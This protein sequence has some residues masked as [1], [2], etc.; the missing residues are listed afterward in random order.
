MLLLILSKYNNENHL[1]DLA[2][3]IHYL[4][5]GGNNATAD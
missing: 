1:Q 5:T 3:N 4:L 2:L